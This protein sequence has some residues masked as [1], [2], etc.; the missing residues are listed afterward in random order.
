MPF[1][2]LC[3]LFRRSRVPLYLRHLLSLRDLRYIPLRYLC[4]PCY[5]TYIIYITYTR[6]RVSKQMD[7]T[8]CITYTRDKAKIACRNSGQN[9]DDH[10]EDIL[11][12]VE[13]RTPFWVVSKME[14]TTS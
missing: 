2:V 11:E 14:S 9:V 13:T 10:F 8:F 4:F 5:A 12:M 3:Y 7:N 1:C 6:T